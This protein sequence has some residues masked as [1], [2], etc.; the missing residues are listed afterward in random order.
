MRRQVVP[1]GLHESLPSQTCLDSL[2]G[3]PNLFFAGA[4]ATVSLLILFSWSFLKN[5]FLL[6][7]E[8][9]Y[10]FHSSYPFLSVFYLIPQRVQ[11][12]P[13]QAE[14]IL[15]AWDTLAIDGIFF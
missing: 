1:V 3:W 11:I 13:H 9:M 10:L 15:C 7:S 4:F 14:A 6:P 8:D 5:T 2:I 12:Q